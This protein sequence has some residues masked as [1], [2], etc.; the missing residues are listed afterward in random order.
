MKIIKLLALLFLSAGLLFSSA[1]LLAG[2]A[3][4]ERA[5]PPPLRPRYVNGVLY[6]PATMASREYGVEAAR[7]TL[8]PGWRWPKSPLARFKEREPMY[9]EVGF[10][11]QAA[12]SYWFCSWAYTAL[13][14]TGNEKQ[15]ALKVIPGIRH[16]YYYTTSLVPPSRVLLNKELIEAQHG[17]LSRLRTD[18]TLNCPRP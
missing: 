7:L 8:A 6:L 3:R 9:Y 17:H 1:G 4:A 18:V 15:T 5:K 2:C 12:D 16:L 14:D 13:H 11:K 10:G